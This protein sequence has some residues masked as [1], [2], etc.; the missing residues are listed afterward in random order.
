MQVVKS[1]FNN[2]LLRLK[3]SQRDGYFVK[4]RNS[5]NKLIIRIDT[6]YTH[7]RMAQL[8]EIFRNCMFYKIGLIVEAVE[9]KIECSFINLEAL[10]Y[11]PYWDLYLIKFLNISLSTLDTHNTVHHLESIVIRPDSHINGK[12]KYELLTLIEK[13]LN[14]FLN[15]Y[16]IIGY[17]RLSLYETEYN[18]IKV[19]IKLFTPNNIHKN[20]N[21]YKNELYM[22][23]LYF[24]LYQKIHKK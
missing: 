22:D 14:K 5:N 2:S 10:N 7:E 19:D 16:E 17:F 13:V 8:H 23:E 20:D 9:S 21:V 3:H 18:T 6:E 15:H 24:L 12:V 1:L 4:E 11:N